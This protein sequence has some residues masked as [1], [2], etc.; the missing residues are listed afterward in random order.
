MIKKLVLVT[1]LFLGVTSLTAQTVEELKKDQTVKKDSIAAIQGRVD[2]IQAQIDAIPG[3]KI[4]AFGTIGGSISGFNNWF[5]QEIPNNSAGTIGV[6]VNAYANLLQEKYFWRNSANVNLAWIKLDDKDNDDDIPVVDDNDFREATDV[7]NITSLF[8]YKLTKTLAVS[9]LAEYRTTILNNFNDPGYLDFGVGITW[10]PVKDLV[11]VV[12]P[13]NYNFVFSKGSAEY[14]SSLGAKIVADYTRKI[15]AINFKTNVSAFL[16]YEDPD[17]S[18]WTWTNSFSYTLWKAIGVGFDFGLRG[19]KQ[20][21]FNY[22]LAQDALLVPPPTME[23]TLE[24]TDNELQS[25]W[26]IGLSYSF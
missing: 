20:E 18:N 2:A 22:V 8:G 12:H 26:N 5:A 24:N 13:L 11:V 4:G 14:E 6:T 10:T 19:N 16:S 15:G 3:W 21:A 17:Y 7:F 25:F 1:T 9:T 23:R